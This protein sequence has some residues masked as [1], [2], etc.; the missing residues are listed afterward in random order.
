MLRAIKEN[1]SNFLK[2]NLIYSLITILGGTFLVSIVDFLYHFISV[3]ILT[4]EDYGLFNSLISVISII[5][6]AINPLSMAFARFFAEYTAKGEF[7]NAHKLFEEIN[8]RLFIASCILF[9][10]FMITSQFLAKFLLTQTI[11]IVICTLTIILSLFSKTILSFFQGFQK[12]NTYYSLYSASSFIKLILGISLLLFGFKVLGALIGFLI[13]PL[14][15]I[16]TGFFLIPKSHNQK[17]ISLGKVELRQTFLRLYKMLF[18][19]SISMLA[20]AIFINIDSILVKH[21]F[22]PLDVGYYSIAQMAG[23]ITLL[24]PMAIS[25]AMLPKCTV[26]FIKN[27]RPLKLLYKSL[28]FS[29][30]CCMPIILWSLFYPASLINIITGRPNVVSNSLVGLYSIAMFFYSLLWALINFALAIEKFNFKW[31]ILALSLLEAVF[32]YA[33]HPTL[34]VVI[35][36]TLIFSIV[37]FGVTLINLRQPNLKN[38]I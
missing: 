37:S 31:L 35:L 27:G 4:Y 30:A 12:F 32:I 2:D 21:F 29:A 34:K 28:F 14:L 33:C 18:P 17:N 24:I 26:A 16:L 1:T 36:I 11:F 10:L 3:R 8:K 9:V 25:I 20:L 19:I 15:I 38:T 23:K 13:Q 6:I 5:V 7:D 22:L